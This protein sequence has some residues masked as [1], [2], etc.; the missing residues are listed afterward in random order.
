MEIF[1]WY[2]L[3]IKITNS[4]VVNKLQSYSRISALG[5]FQKSD[6]Y[7]MSIACGRPQGGSGSCGRGRGPKTQFF[8]WTS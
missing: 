6:V 1:L 4:T 7:F 2:K 3:V 8:L 5:P